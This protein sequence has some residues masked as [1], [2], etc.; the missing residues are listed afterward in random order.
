MRWTIAAH[1]QRALKRPSGATRK[2]TRAEAD[3]DTDSKPVDRPSQETVK[4]RQGTGP[5]ATVSVLLISVMLALLVGVVIVG[6]FIL[7]H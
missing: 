7:G 4:V 3:M 1:H 2:H 6:S 5:R